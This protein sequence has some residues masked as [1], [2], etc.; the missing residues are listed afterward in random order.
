M[1]R[2]LLAVGE[3]KTIGVDRTTDGGGGSDGA[4]QRGGFRWGGLRW[5]GF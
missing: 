5:G 3:G 4:V 2:L 1:K